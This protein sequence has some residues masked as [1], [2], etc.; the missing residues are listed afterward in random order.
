[1]GSSTISLGLGLG[2][3]KA[4]TSSGTAGGGGSVFNNS[5][6]FPIIQVFDTEIEFITQ[7]DAPSY[8]I[9]TAKDTDKFYIWTGVKWIIF[10]KN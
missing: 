6:T 1:M 9:V 2:G 5:L 7:A 3:G 4:A 8:T 10:N